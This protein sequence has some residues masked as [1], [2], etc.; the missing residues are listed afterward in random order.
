M[1]QF[2]EGSSIFDPPC[3]DCQNFSTWKIKFKA[4][5]CSSNFDLWDLIELG[6]EKP[7]CNVNDHSFELPYFQYNDK[8]VLNAKL[9]FEL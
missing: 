4:F 8:Q 1:A 9:N 3:F 2:I 6:F 5:N 7:T